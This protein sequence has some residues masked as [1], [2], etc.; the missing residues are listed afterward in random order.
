MKCLRRSGVVLLL[1]LAASI[2]PVAAPSAAAQSS[3]GV[4]TPHRARGCRHHARS[5]GCDHPA[6]NHRVRHAS[7]RLEHVLNSA[8]DGSFSIS[9]LTPGRYIVTASA[10][11]SASASQVIEV[12]AAEPSRLTL[13]PAPI[14]EQVTVISASRQQ[15][16]RDTLNTRVDVITRRRIEESGG[17]ET[18]GEILRELPG[19]IS[20]RGSETAGAAG[21]Q[22]QGIESRQVLVL[23][24]GQPI[25]GAR[26]IKRGGVLNL[27]RQSTARLDRVEV[28][29]GAASALYGSE[30]LGGVINLITR[31]AVV[32]V[33][34]NVGAVRWQLRCDRRPRR[35]GVQA[36]ERTYRPLQRRAPSARRVRSH[37]V[38]FDTTGAPYH[39]YDLLA[40]LHRQF[41]PSFSLRGLVTGYHNDT[42][43]R[44]NG[45]LGPQEDEIRD[46]A[47]N[48][49]VAA[50][51]LVGGNTTFEARTYV[52]TYSERS[53]GRLAPPR[54]TPLAP[55]ALDQ[56][57]SEGRFSTSRIRSAPA[58]SCRPVSVVTPS[59]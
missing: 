49:N 38:T 55:G 57:L 24:D 48:V 13:S 7:S 12:P 3:G 54:S 17:Q 9:R 10:P 22:I 58:R 19:V 2:L 52:S 18:V 59:L 56:R 11:G 33:R 32:A 51:W 46:Q 31:E 42:A 21:E 47:I 20:R 45:E 39:R 16:L 23:I 53:N 44:S 8:P 28:V 34:R 5:V 37:T 50:H 1:V 43:G 25:V 15:E 27:D 30:A 4:R 14:V 41:T 26:G 29:K 36:A 6:L 35:C 40:K